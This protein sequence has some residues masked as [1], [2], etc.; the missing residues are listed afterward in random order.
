[1]P[2]SNEFAPH[3][4]RTRW[5]L[6]ALGVGVSAFGAYLQFKLPPVLPAFLA[7][8]PHDADMAAGFMSVFAL[9]GLVASA[10]LG[11]VLE[12]RAMLN[13]LFA[14]LGIAALG[15]AIGLVAPQSGPLMLLAR[16]IEGLTFAIFALI[17]PVIANQAAARRDLGLVTG[18]IAT[19]IPI[20]QLLA[21][22]L[23]LMGADWQAL[24]LINLALI[25][26]LA[27]A[28][29]AWRESLGP[30]HRPASASLPGAKTDRALVIG[31]GI[32]L[33]WALQFFAFMTWLTKYLT[34]EL[35]LSASAA[36]LAYLLPVVVIMLF[37]VG[38]GWLLARGMKLLP[39]LIIALLM[40]SLV[41]LSAPWLA[42]GTGILMLVVYGIGAGVAPACFFHLPHH[43]AR[44][45]T[46]IGP[47]AYGVLMTGRNSGVLLGPIL[48]AW[49]F[50][51]DLG[52][53]GAAFVVA[54][55]T[56]TSALLAALLANANK[57][58]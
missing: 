25:L 56:A 32:F 14:G 42:G 52:W 20:G 51:G 5:K 21:G 58:P 19:W 43:L 2:A 50:Q 13:A 35:H 31:A 10:P 34:G 18:L 1:M 27:W 55:I 40:Q 54:G 8:Y 23:A 30:I 15:I 36:I 6:V 11:R 47:K 29:W 24:W 41:W 7:T 37:N 4:E 28:G 38:T 17:G 44:A 48:M 46:A 9:I 22:L 53:S 39:A 3:T 33:L 12:R 45:G 16:G 26:P 57:G 49:L